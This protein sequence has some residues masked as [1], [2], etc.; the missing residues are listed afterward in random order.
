MPPARYKKT[1]PPKKR[2]KKNKKRQ[3]EPA[4]NQGPTKPVE[5]EAD[6]LRVDAPIELDVKTPV[7]VTRERQ[8]VRR[9]QPVEINLN[10]RGER[11][12]LTQ[13]QVN[14]LIARFENVMR[15]ERE[16]RTPQETKKAEREVTRISEFVERLMRE[17]AGL[18]PGERA[19]NSDVASKWLDVWREGG[20]NT[21]KAIKEFYHAWRNEIAASIYE[22]ERAVESLQR[23]IQNQRK[24]IRNVLLKGG[25]RKKARLVRY[26]REL[27]EMQHSLRVL[28]NG[29]EGFKRQIAAPSIVA[30][31]KA[32][33]DYRVQSKENPEEAMAN[34]WKK[35]LEANNQYGIINTFL[36]A[37]EEFVKSVI[38]RRFLRHEAQMRRNLG[39]PAGPISSWF[40]IVRRNPFTF[41]KFER[42]LKEYIQ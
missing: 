2:G 14:N 39:L 30:L 13:E 33:L 20:I 17:G 19:M 23:A 35:M 29:L 12:A 26:W 38:G 7:H 21:S 27:R 24:E 9:R 41:S 1:N 42:R 40:G 5:F 15:M 32:F 6:H 31:E 34:F 37:K 25:I 4:Q 16:A 3:Q 36:Q 10:L 28:Q 18:P 11:G 22:N 8:R